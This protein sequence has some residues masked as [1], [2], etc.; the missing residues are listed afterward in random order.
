MEVSAPDF[1]EQIGLRSAFLRGLQEVRAPVL[2]WGLGLAVFSA[3]MTAIAPNLRAAYTESSGPFRSIIGAGQITDSRIISLLVFGF[4]PL[5]AS[6]YAVTLAA[7]WAD[8][9]LDGR[10]EL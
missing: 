5:L 8:E 10:L 1:R 4:V 2:A 6:F 9:E 3:A 7:S